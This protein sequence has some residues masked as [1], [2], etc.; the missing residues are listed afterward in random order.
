MIMGCPHDA[1]RPRQGGPVTYTYCETGHV[2]NITIRDGD[3]RVAACGSQA[4][5]DGTSGKP[6]D[7]IRDTWVCHDLGLFYTTDGK[8]WRSRWS[9]WDENSEGP[10]GSV[11]HDAARKFYYIGPRQ[12]YLTWEADP[13]TWELLEEGEEPTQTWTTYLGDMPWADFTV[14]ADWN[15]T[16]VRDYVTGDGLHAQKDTADPPN[17]EFLHGDLIGSTMLRTDDSGEPVSGVS[18]ITY[19]AFGEPVVNTG[20]GWQ[21]SGS[22]PE[23]YPR[24]AYAGQFGYESDLLTVQGTNETLAPVT[25][26]HVGWRWYQPGIGRF[27]QRDPIGLSGGLNVYAYVGSAPT[28]QVDPEGTNFWGWLKGL[29]RRLFGKKPKVVKTTYK[30]NTSLSLS[31][32]DKVP[33]G[34]NE[35][36]NCLIPFYVPEGQMMME[37]PEYYA[38]GGYGGWGG[39]GYGGA[40]YSVAP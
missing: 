28:F 24:Y 21:V 13:T 25:L 23:G 10:V 14:D 6:P 11:T 16:K 26:A 9:H 40:I 36:L 33:Y 17:V 1:Q 7:A 29:V 27:V 32:P 15:P 34:L 22:L 2:S 35:I 3:P 4:V 12:R 19:T 37:Y 38:P 20:S 30:L 8:L 39:G 18:G 31:G 5:G